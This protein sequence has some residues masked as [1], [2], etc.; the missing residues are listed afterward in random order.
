MKSFKEQ[1]DE[2]INEKESMESS[3]KREN[4]EEYKK[5]KFDAINDSYLAGGSEYIVIRQNIKT[6]IQAGEGFIS[7][8]NLMRVGY[9]IK[10]YTGLIF[11]EM[12]EIQNSIN[13]L[14]ECLD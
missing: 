4:P 14:E 9:D 10:G 11:D 12:Q 13:K 1:A 3:A 2:L 6:L 7:K 5:N 8:L